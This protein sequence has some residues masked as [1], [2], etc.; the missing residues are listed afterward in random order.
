MRPSNPPLLEWY[1]SHDQWREEHEALRDRLLELCRMM[2]WNPANYDYPDWEAHHLAVREKF[3]PF[4]RDWLRHL[5]ME[6]RTVYPVA[7]TAICGGRIGPVSV[8]EQD[9]RI[10][11]QF[12]DAYLQAAG[13]DA[14]PEDALSHLL[15]VL[16]IVAE[17][18]RVEEELV[19]PAAERLME[20]I[21]YSGS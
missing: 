1:L 5:A 7:R 12:Y 13:R 2:K 17:H 16:I 6:R 19:M 18:F 4:M 15:Q 21:E 20:E 8:L 10:A 11:G 3:I 14:S 9:E